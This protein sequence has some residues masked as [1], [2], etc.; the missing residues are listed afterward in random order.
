[1][2]SV[3]KKRKVKMNRHKW[4]KLRRRTRFLRRNK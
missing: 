1:M 4:K 3:V 2:S